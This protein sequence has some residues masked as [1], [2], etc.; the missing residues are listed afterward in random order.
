MHDLAYGFATQRHDVHVITRAWNGKE[1]TQRE[2]EVVIH[3]VCPIDVSL[4][5]FW[6]IE[7]FLP[8][9]TLQMLRYSIR[10]NRKL[11]ELIIGGEVDIVVSV[12]GTVE[13]VWF[14]LFQKTVPLV[15]SL[16]GP[17]FINLRRDGIHLGFDAHL[18]MWIERLLI[19][20]ADYLHAV[21]RR[22]SY[23]VLKEIRTAHLPIQVIH[24]PVNIERFNM[25]NRREGKAGGQQRV[26]FVGRLET[27]KGVEVLA[28]AI[29]LVHQRSPDVEFV[30]VGHDTTEGPNC[31]SMQEYL[32][33]L[34]GASASKIKFLGQLRTEE[35][36][37]H[38]Q[39]STLCVFPSLEEPFGNVCIEAMACGKPVVA[40][41]NTGFAEI[42]T[43][44]M[45]GFLL[46]PYDVKGLADAILK[47][48]LDKS[49]RTQLGEEARRTIERRFTL[50]QITSQW[51]GLLE[52]LVT[53]KSWRETKRLKVPFHPTREVFRD[54]KHREVCQEL[55][56]KL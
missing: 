19:R 40:T 39:G 37:S 13:A 30:F 27:R 3:R 52:N 10:V 49:L 33:T 38:Y 32:R 15:L 21:S 46:K 47:L 6:K 44:G 43:S 12:S 11:Q 7:K 5:G 45:D 20:R 1:S 23:Q 55:L 26:V 34:V 18:Q 56:E 2:G 29:P 31:S 25:K 28:K 48:L 53:Q 24:N 16:Q 14:T 8:P 35:V 36:V 4:R 50:S 17:L 51:L 42:I 9:R 22:V 54:R 41:S